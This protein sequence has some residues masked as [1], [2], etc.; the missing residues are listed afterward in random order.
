MGF[1]VLGVGFRVEGLVSGVARFNVF[2]LGFSLY[3]VFLLDYTK[4]ALFVVRLV[5]VARGFDL[6]QPLILQNHFNGR[7]YNISGV[8]FRA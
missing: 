2:G 1:R 4:D 8:G 3:G 6:I 5:L 7:W